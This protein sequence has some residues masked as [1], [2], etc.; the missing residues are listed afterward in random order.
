MEVFKTKPEVFSYIRSKFSTK[1]VK[2]IAIVGSTAKG[3]I[4]NFSD[5]DVVVF[6]EKPFKPHYELCLIGSKLVLITIYFYKS[7]K[8]IN[9][10]KN[11]KIVY[12]KY[13]SQIEHEGNLNYDVKGRI[14]RDNQ[15][16]LDGLFKFLRTKD[17]QY[18]S[19]IDKYIRF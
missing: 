15:M 5:I 8:E 3:K 14:K 18:L 13:Y 9:L 6:S 11:G 10:P 1:D 4:K 16:F 7:G 19:W 12:G 17:K 2:G